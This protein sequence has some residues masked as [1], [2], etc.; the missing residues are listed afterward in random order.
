MAKYRK[1]GLLMKCVLLT[2][3]LATLSFSF[4]AFAKKPVTVK[5]AS[6]WF[7]E[8]GRKEWLNAHLDK[9][10][11]EN[12]GIKIERIAIGSTDVHDKFMTEAAA[13]TGPDVLWLRHVSLGPFA[14][15]GFL[16]PLDKYINFN[17]YDLEDLNKDAVI[18][19]KRYALNLMS[20]AY[21][22]LIYNKKMFAEAGLKPPTTPE[23]LIDVAK[24]LTKAP[25]IY[26][27]GMP[28][29]PTESEYFA[30]VIQKFASG[31]NAGIANKDG[32][33]AVNDEKFI[34]AIKWYKKVYDA[35]VTP[36]G[37]GWKVQ[38]KMFADGKIAMINDGAY[39]FGI[40]DG[41]YPGKSK[42][43]DAIRPPFPGNRILFDQNFVAMNKNSKNKK[44]AAKFIEW[45]IRSDNQ[46]EY[47][48]YGLHIGTTK[49][50]FPK[51]WLEDRPYYKAYMDP[52]LIPMPTVVVG[53]EAETEQIRRILVNH[54]AD[55]IYK[56]KPVEDALNDAQK[57]IMGIIKK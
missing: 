15:M 42:E 27:L 8:A 44:E 39:Q 22:H 9:F 37:I 56:N 13:G 48:T 31:F 55:V 26:G 18:N 53:Y 16:E 12:P 30:Q 24:K 25:D 41:F 49:V 4:T 19:G 40:I 11:K 51:K 47:N 3:T 35:N 1:S 46:L 38:R 50:Q 52:S 29:L 45:W 23:E 10:E 34:E 33:I 20:Y 17:K 7:T 32:K 6:W 43:F 5:F 54:V 21:G 2:F 14:K 28:V 36:R 57:E